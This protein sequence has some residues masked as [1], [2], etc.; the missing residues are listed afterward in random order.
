[1]D[2]AWATMIALEDIEPDT[3]VDLIGARIAKLQA[4]TEWSRAKHKLRN[5]LYQTLK[6][7]GYCSFFTD[8]RD[9]HL[10]RVGQSFQYVVPLDKRGNLQPYRGRRV[11]LVCVWNGRFR[12][13]TMV[14][15]VNDIDIGRRALWRFN[16]TSA[17][18]GR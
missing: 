11:R 16:K 6:H 14:G 3:R 17:S 18:E 10:H 12:V 4:I 1:M 8:K 13:Q 15:L 9:Y 5:D 7:F 2:L